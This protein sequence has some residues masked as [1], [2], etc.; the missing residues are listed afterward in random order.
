MMDVEG[1]A[2]Q[3]FFVISEVKPFEASLI[4]SLGLPII[5]KTPNM[6]FYGDPCHVTSQQRLL[7]Y[8]S[9]VKPLSSWNICR[10]RTHMTPWNPH[11]YS[12]CNNNSLH[13]SI[14]FAQPV[15]IPFRSFLGVWK[16]YCSPCRQ[17]CQLWQLRIIS[18][19][20]LF[21]L[22]V[23]LSILLICNRNTTMRL[24]LV[25]SSLYAMNLVLCL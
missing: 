22:A 20:F 19:M 13:L 12:I 16:T 21:C 7:L 4:S 15:W 17:T 23:I 9:S 6:Q 2:L 3:V 24:Q 11:T 8:S 1:S 10:Q 25:R 18:D 5:R 14:R